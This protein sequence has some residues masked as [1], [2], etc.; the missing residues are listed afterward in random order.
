MLGHD[1]S[2]NRVL[3][4]QRSIVKPVVIEDD[5]FI[6]HGA[7]IL[8]G[9]TIGKGSIV[10]AGAVVREDV[11]PGSVVIGNPA[12]IVGTVSELAQRRRGLALEHPEFFPSKPR[13]L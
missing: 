10:G 8:M 13:G 1:A 2:T 12:R 4:L 9:V 7:I 5:C 6:G 3:G 11:P